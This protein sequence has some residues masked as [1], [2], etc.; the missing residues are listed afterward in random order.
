MGFE[1]KRT[2]CSWIYVPNDTKWQH[3]QAL[4]LI[5]T[6]LGTFSNVIFEVSVC[7]DGAYWRIVEYNQGKQKFLQQLINTVY[8]DAVVEWEHVWYQLPENQQVYRYISDYELVEPH[9]PYAPLP[10]V[11]EIQNS[12]PLALLAQASANLEENES[13]VFSLNVFHTKKK[14]S[15]LFGSAANL[16]SKAAY[17]S[18]LEK[19]SQHDRKLIEKKWYGHKYGA[20]LI[21]SIEAN[22]MARVK[23]LGAWVENFV[24]KQFQRQSP[25]SYLK[26]NQVKLEIVDDE[27][28]GLSLLPSLLHGSP[29]FRKSFYVLTEEV[30]ALWHLPHDGIHPSAV[31]WLEAPEN[32]DIPE[33]LVGK[34]EGIPLGEGT[35][36][37]ERHP[38]YIPT[39][40]R[41][42]HT[43]IVGQTGTGKSTFLLNLVMQDIQNGEGLMVI[44][45]HGELISK[46]LQR[47]PSEREDDIVVLDIANKEYPIPLNVFGVGNSGGGNK[48]VV[49]IIDKLMPPAGARMPRFLAAAVSTLMAQSQAT[50]QDVQKLFMDASYRTNATSQLFDLED[51]Y[52]MG[53]WQQ[54][55]TLS[56]GEKNQVAEPILNRVDFFIRN[57][58]LY[59]TLCHP[60]TLDI[61]QLIK[62]RKVVLVSLGVDSDIVPKKER[63]LVG[64][65]LIALIQIAGMKK[66]RIE[67]G[68]KPFYVYIDEVQNFV[69]GSE[70]LETI[71]S[72][73]RKYQLPLIMANQYYDQL[74]DGMVKAILGNVSTSVAFRVSPDDARKLSD[75]MHPSFERHDLSNM[76]KYTNAVK[77]QYHG[78]TLPAFKIHTYP[79]PE[80]PEPTAEELANLEEQLASYPTEEL[81]KYRQ[82]FAE[83]F[84]SERERRIRQKSIKK[85]TPKTRKEVLDWLKAQYLGVDT[86]TPD[87]DEPEDIDKDDDIFEP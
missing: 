58:H 33:I 10:L 61:E 53:V 44:D 39:K 66:H 7:A 74:T 32:T 82:Q 37:E 56:Q 30:A 75:Y 71:L 86:D 40:D 59:P 69:S 6:I 50:P 67:A 15:G 21:T 80:P 52:S 12:D 34:N 8:P 22:R 62:Q 81:E 31:E 78:D 42:T 55:E 76:S 11:S 72:E 36:N 16:V 29:E 26:V 85:Y 70:T 25:R 68:T 60:D 1:D 43:S 3:Q 27:D 45:P 19:A 35:Y 2:F 18:V 47:I 38:V 51:F 23:Q 84:I 63:N 87:D 49:D 41:M 48:L 24:R 13:I 65:L 73:A 20:R 77:M 64:A 4:Q 14:D 46:V 28:R 54:Y 79:D 9:N 57:R 83:Y 17:Q 5:E